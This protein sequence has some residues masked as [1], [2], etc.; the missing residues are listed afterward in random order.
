MLQPKKKKNQ[1]AE[2]IQQQDLLSTKNPLQ[3]SRH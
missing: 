1:T 2:W 3:T